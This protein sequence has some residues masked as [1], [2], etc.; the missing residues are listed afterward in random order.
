MQTTQLNK[1]LDNMKTNKKGKRTESS[2]ISSIFYISL[3]IDH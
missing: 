3:I 2:V 1:Y